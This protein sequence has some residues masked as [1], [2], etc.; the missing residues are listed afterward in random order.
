MVDTNKSCLHLVYEWW[1]AMIKKVKAA[2][3]RNKCKALHENNSF[4]YA[5]YHILLE[6]WTKSNTPLHCLGHSLNPRYYS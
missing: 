2:I 5:L 4:L 1:D 6:R 3:Y